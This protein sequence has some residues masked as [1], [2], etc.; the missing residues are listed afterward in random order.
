M[1]GMGLGK[2]QDRLLEKDALNVVVT[3]A[4]LMEVVINK[5]TANASNQW[6]AQG[7]TENGEYHETN[8]AQSQADISI[9]SHRRNTYDVGDK[10]PYFESPWS[11]K[12]QF[13]PFF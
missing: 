7:I 4:K 2:I 11:F 5:E 9:H 12:V 13:C 3:L 10:I 8:A 6:V 1:A